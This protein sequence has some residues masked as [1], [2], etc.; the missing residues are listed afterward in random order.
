MLRSK[1]THHHNYSGIFRQG[2]YRIVRSGYEGAEG[3]SPHI[4][5][6]L[7]GDRSFYPV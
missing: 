7:P 4:L 3:I 2:E 6:A 1:V 5:Y